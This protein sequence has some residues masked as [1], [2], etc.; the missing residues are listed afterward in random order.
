MRA[1]LR[2]AVLSVVLVLTATTAF[3]D[4]IGS[5]FYLDPVGGYTV[6]DTN[7]KYPR[8]HTLKD[9]IYVGGRFGYRFNRWLAFELGGGF[10]P[11]R[12]DYFG[13][14]RDVDFMHGSADFLISPFNG[15]WGAPYLLIGGGAARMKLSGG[16][17]RHNQGNAELGLGV[18]FWLTDAVGVR[19]EARDLFALDKESVTDVVT[20]TWAFTGGLSFPLG[21]KGRDTDG[22]G[23]PD[24]KDH[25]AKT[26]AG[27]VVDESGCPLDSD[28]DGVYDGLDQCAA[29]PAG[30]TV[31]ANGCP[32]DSDGDGVF[33]GIDQCADTPAGATVDATGCPSDSDGD[34]VLDGLDKCENTPAGA[35][36]DASGCPTDE[37]GDGIFDGIDQCPGTSP[38]LKVDKD[39]CPIEVIERETEL[40]DTGMIRLQNIN[41]ETG[42]AELS[43]D[44]LPQL[45]IAGQVLAKWSE[46]RIEIGGHA[47]ARGSA[48]FN[49][50]LS[51]ERVQAVLEYLLERYPNLN[52]DQYTVKGYG[53]SQPLVPNTSAL[54]MAKNRRV[55][56]KVLN[57]EV[58]K[59]EIERRKLLRNDEQ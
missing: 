19:A 53:E 24:R 39:G 14:T 54:N 11:T 52:P 2:S 38:G 25:C 28:G 6:Y 22:D 55:E 26:P 16:A 45:D 42:K 29:T 10:S 32:S 35:T 58:L 46:L 43:P 8:F 3:A 37:D 31:D 57:T 18:L 34:G 1:G 23:V 4:P 56:F 49:Q 27:A 21:A 51:E 41:F 9:D 47:D 7:G 50:K 33:D 17:E 12:G 5:F 44:A 13:E 59:R 20:Q 30:A 36:V 48:A 40:L 15:P